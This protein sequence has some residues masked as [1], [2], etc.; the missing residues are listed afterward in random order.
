MYRTEEPA[1]EDL[2]DEA[3]EGFRD[4]GWVRWVRTKSCRTLDSSKL[5]RTLSSLRSVGL[6]SYAAYVGVM[7]T[8]MNHLTFRM[9][10]VKPLEQESYKSLQQRQ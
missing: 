7:L 3:R 8:S 1:E 4:M 9:E 2:E 6:L 5:R 10:I